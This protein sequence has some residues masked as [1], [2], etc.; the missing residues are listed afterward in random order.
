MTTIELPTAFVKALLDDFRS[1][2]EE[3][4]RT[5]KEVSER[6]R[7]LAKAHGVPSHLIETLDFWMRY[8]DS[9]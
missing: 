9:G 4:N 5:T 6:L 8:G 1:G 7:D 3:H 2:G